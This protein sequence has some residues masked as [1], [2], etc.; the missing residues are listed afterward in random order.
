MLK[1]IVYDSKAQIEEKNSDGK[2]IK[3]IF[4]IHFHNQV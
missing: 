1:K 3:Y 4:E 2:V